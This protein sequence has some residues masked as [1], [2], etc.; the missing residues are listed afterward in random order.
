VTIAQTLARAWERAARKWRAPNCAACAPRSWRSSTEKACIALRPATA[1]HINA[2]CLN[3]R[4]ELVV[5]MRWSRTSMPSASP[6]A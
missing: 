3:E 5:T 6:M 1:T 4:N 2:R